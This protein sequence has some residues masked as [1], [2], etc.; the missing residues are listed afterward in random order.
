[1]NPTDIGPRLSFEEP[2]SSG[3][4]SADNADHAPEHATH[5]QPL[6]LG[7]A[8]LN[9]LFG[10]QVEGELI[11]CLLDPE[12]IPLMRFSCSSLAPWMFWG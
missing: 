6:E 10:Y 7:E 1:M 11:S 8:V 12:S 3:E 9:A 4:Y 2:Y 5:F